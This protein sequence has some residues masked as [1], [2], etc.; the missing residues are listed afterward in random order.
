MDTTLKNYWIFSINGHHKNFDYIKHSNQDIN[1][2]YIITNLIRLFTDEL[3][4][5]SYISL[6]QQTKGNEG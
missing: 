4:Y 6:M 1:L 2:V 3:S 5:K